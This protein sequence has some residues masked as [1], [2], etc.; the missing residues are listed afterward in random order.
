MI[1]VTLHQ[2]MYT[3]NVNNTAGH[4][5]ARWCLPRLI[6]D[7][8]DGGGTF[9]RNVGS[10]TDYTV[11]YSRRWQLSTLMHLRADYHC[12]DGGSGF[13]PNVCSRVPDYTVSLSKR[14]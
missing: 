12:E 1:A 2:H 3:T 6:F 14:L 4:L 13:F 10:Y 5:L 8:D 9:L 7:P 11:P